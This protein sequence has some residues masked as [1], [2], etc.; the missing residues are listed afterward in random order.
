MEAALERYRIP[1]I[2]ESMFYIHDYISLEEEAKILSQIPKNKWITLSHRRLQAVPAPLSGN[3][4][5]LTTRELPVYLY[6][7]VV[8]RL[9]NDF[10]FEKINHCLINEYPP[11]V[12]IMAHEDGPAYHPMVATVSLGGSIVLDVAEKGGEAKRWHILQ[13]PRSL[14]VTMGQAYTETR[15]GIG[16]VLRDEGLE[17]ETVANWDLLGV[18]ERKSIEENGGVNVRQT[19]VSL[20]FRSV[21]KVSTLGGKVFGKVRR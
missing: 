20:T 15:H 16:D 18:E 19:R 1:D 14:L 13:E 8:N 4:T 10:D 6:N 17:R 11:G 12:G 5:L 3:N 21:K 9:H 2:P 7:P